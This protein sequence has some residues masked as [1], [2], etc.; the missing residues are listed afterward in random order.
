M[1]ILVNEKLDMNQQC[2]LA[3]QKAN[4][5]LSCTKRSVVSKSREEILPVHSAL[6]RP[7]LESCI[8]LWSPQ[9]RED[10]DL[11]DWVQRRATKMIRELEHLS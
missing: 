4:C 6:V 7:H 10:M 8:Q 3:A 9:H 2:V 11:S 1:G 5:I